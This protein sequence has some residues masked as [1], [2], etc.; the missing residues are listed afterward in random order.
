MQASGSS[1]TGL[2]DV[3]SNGTRI[4][5]TSDTPKC[6]ITE[7]IYK[8]A[9][10]FRTIPQ[11]HHRSVIPDLLPFYVSCNGLFIITL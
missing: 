5:V 3:K 10:D 7:T 4:H 8:E 6:H 2:S 11:C 1:G 9:K